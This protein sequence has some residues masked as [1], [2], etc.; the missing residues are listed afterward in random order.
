MRKLWI[1]ILVLGAM[2]AACGDGPG[3]KSDEGARQAAPIIEPGVDDAQVMREAEENRKR[4]RGSGKGKYTPQ[5][6]DG[7]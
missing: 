6:V 3:D 4:F 7:F 1:P 5:P 2:L